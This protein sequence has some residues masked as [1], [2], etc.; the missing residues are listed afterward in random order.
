MIKIRLHT[1]EMLQ[2]RTDYFCYKSRR[3]SAYFLKKSPTVCEPCGESIP[4]LQSLID[5]QRSR[6]IY[7]FNG[8]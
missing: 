3:W 7:H 2:Q 4:N 6:R 1:Q 5:N 8:V